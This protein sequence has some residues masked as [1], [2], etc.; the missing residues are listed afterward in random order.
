MAPL[1]P[2]RHPTTNPPPHDPRY[3]HGIAP[4]TVIVS[5]LSTST[6]VA[7]VEAGLKAA[8]FAP[9]AVEIFEDE[10]DKTFG[11]GVITFHEKV[12]KTTL[13]DLMNVK[14]DNDGQLRELIWT[15]LE[16][17]ERGRTAALSLTHSTRAAFAQ[18]HTRH[19]LAHRH[20]HTRHHLAH[21][22]TH[23]PDTTSPIVTHTPD[24]TSPVV[25]HTT[26]PHASRPPHTH[27]TTPPH[28]HPPPLDTT[29]GGRG[30]A[31]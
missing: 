9:E 3:N 25:T 17:R 6:N 14:V 19:H 1:P 18:T 22:H 26:R 16:V 10:G 7:H 31:A 15:P 2:P 30:R 28:T 12:D 27:S 8:E 21:R 11:L 29:S 20:T 13:A 5:N 23:T 24:T 4:R